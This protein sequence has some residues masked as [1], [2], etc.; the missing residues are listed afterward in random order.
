MTYNMALSA[1]YQPSNGSRKRWSRPQGS[2]FSP[3]PNHLT[4]LGWTPFSTNKAQPQ[5]YA[6]QSQ[7]SSSPP[8]NSPARPQPPRPATA[9]EFDKPAWAETLRSSGG[10]RH[11]E[12]TQAESITPGSVPRQYREAHSEPP[13]MPQVHRA[14][15]GGSGVTPVQPHQPKIQ[16]M[17]YGPTGQQVYEQHEA[18]QYGDSDSARVVHLQYNTPLGLY[19]R[20]NVEQALEGQTHNKAGYGT[21]E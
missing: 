6:R 19:S 17:R 3:A 14:N 20:E 16:V 7:R 13:A 2:T 1:G 9:H 12:M 18:P 15:S 10:P 5:R 4:D 8:V 21:M 11:W